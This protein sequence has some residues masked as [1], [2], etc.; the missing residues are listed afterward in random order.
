MSSEFIF[1][2]I[3]KVNSREKSSGIEHEFTF[4][5][6]IP[7]GSEKMTLQKLLPNFNIIK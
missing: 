3:G 7:Y 6:G 5:R 2:S 1:Y 4:L